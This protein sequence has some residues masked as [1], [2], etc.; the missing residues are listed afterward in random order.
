MLNDTKDLPSS[1][2]LFRYGRMHTNE[3]TISWGWGTSTSK[4]VS[5]LLNCLESCCHCFTSE[6]TSVFYWNEK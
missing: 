5:T 2:I 6:S 4:L 3:V 1:N